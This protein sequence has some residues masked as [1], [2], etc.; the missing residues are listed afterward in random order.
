MQSQMDQSQELNGEPALRVVNQSRIENR[1]SKM[2]PLCVTRGDYGA[3]ISP[4]HQAVPIQVDRP[5][6]GKIPSRPLPTP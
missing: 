3:V 4:V 6:V 1:E 5:L 2:A